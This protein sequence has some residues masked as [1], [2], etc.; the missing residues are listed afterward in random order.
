MGGDAEGLLIVP[1]WN[2]KWTRW[3]KRRLQMTFNR[4]IL[5]LKGC[6]LR[7]WENGYHLL[8]VPYWNW[9]TIINDYWHIWNFTFNRTI[10]ELKVNEQVNILVGTGTF[11][12]TILE[13]KGVKGAR[14]FSYLRTFN[15]TIL[16]LKDGTIKHDFKKIAAFNR[17]I[18]E[19][20]DRLLDWNIHE[21]GLLIVPY[22]NWKHYVD[23]GLLLFIFF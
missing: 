5:E 1:Y 22:W 12:R 4:T 9:K 23:E 20:K 7:E 10:L 11:N 18:L 8:I 21:Q 2:W 14:L 19:L 15:R 3:A 17:T 6:S 16:E 13:L